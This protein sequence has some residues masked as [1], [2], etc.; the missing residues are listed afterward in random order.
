MKRFVLEVVVVLGAF[1]LGMAVQRRPVE[2][3]TLKLPE[4][5]LRP[6]HIFA[7]VGQNFLPECRVELIPAGLLPRHY[8]SV[9][10]RIEQLHR[11]GHVEIAQPQ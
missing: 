9:D 4:S 5:G 11:Y 10:E 8:K 2:T 7:L 6:P 3:L 1:V